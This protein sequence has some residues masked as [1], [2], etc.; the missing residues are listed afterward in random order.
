MPHYL[1]LLIECPVVIAAIFISGIGGTFQYGY[2]ISV[3]TSPSTFIM[4]L[5][6]KT[7]EHRYRFTLEK[8]HV[9][10]IWS[11]TVSIFCIG[12]LLGSLMAGSF[13]SKFGRKRCLF[14]NNFVAIFGA[15]LMI[16]SQ[17]ALSFEMIM[18]GRF[19]YGINSVSLS[20]H[21]MYLT[22]CAP[23]RL[24]GMVGVTIATFISLGKFSGQLLGISELLGTEKAWPWLLGFNG[25][26]ALFQ[27]L[28]LPFLPESPS[29]LLMYR[30]DQQACE[31]VLKKLW[32][33]K[34]YSGEVAEMLEERAAL[35]SVHSHSVLE[36]IQTQAVRW[37]LLTIIV[38]FTTLQLSGINAVYFYSFEVFR[39]AGIQEHKIRY[40]ALGTG[41]CELFTSVTCFLIIESMGKKVLLFRGYMGMTGTLILLTISVYLQRQVS[42]MPYCSM[43]LT[44]IFI[45]FFASGPAGVTAPL[46]GEIFTQSFKSAA[47]T[48][49]CTINWT[50]LFVL[51]MVFPLL[52]ENLDSFCFLIFTLFCFGC[53][54]YVKFNVPETKNRTVLEIK[55]EFKKMH[56]K[57]GASEE[58]RSTDHK[59]TTAQETKF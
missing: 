34:D 55:A 28:T 23:K 8:W 56:R 33:N 19:L 6:N 10:L 17:T 25:F 42:W 44:F 48:I 12:G 35:Q 58:K 9:S 54:M 5:I 30:G 29:F 7:C 31:T 27:L 52:V 1:T 49:A 40:A 18:V 2:C 59:E 21:T 14:L 51:G 53:A 3:M 22:E 13:I 41:L 47:Y 45:F 38:T 15:V 43:V 24:R 50:G 46:P 32:G 37:Q 4:D 26:T 16:L 57:P 39:A 36:L 11:F 20:A